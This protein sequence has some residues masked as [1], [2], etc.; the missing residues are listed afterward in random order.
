MLSLKFSMQRIISLN[1]YPVHGRLVESNAFNLIIVVSWGL[2]IQKTCTWLIILKFHFLPLHWQGKGHIFAFCGQLWSWE[3]Q[4][5]TLLSAKGVVL[6]SKT[7]E[8]TPK[9]PSGQ[10]T[11][12]LLR[13][14][15]LKHLG[16]QRQ[17]RGVEHG[18]ISVKCQV[19]C[20]PVQKPTLVRPLLRYWAGK[21]K[22]QL[23]L[24]SPWSPAVVALWRGSCP[25]A[26]PDTS[27]R[28]GW[29]KG[30]G[31]CFCWT[32]STNS[33]S[34]LHTELSHPG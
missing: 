2:F 32:L 8:T 9:L 4:G 11:A 31:G 21:F 30:S 22:G 29:Q 7:R 25:T 16:R 5:K 27:L 19:L 13:P 14:S 26:L 34:S 28:A 33:D 20:V 12:A 17:S 18:D 23:W 10:G 15:E 24:P 3:Q 6:V 1:W